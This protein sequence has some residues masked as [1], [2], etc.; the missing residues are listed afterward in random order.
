MQV[1]PVRG[2]AGAPEAAYWIVGRKNLDIQQGESLNGFEVAAELEPGARH[3]MSI[4][5]RKENFGVYENL[6]WRL[7]LELLAAD[8]RKI[9]AGRGY[10]IPDQYSLRDP[11]SL[12]KTTSTCRRDPRWRR[13]AASS[14]PP[15]TPIRRTVSRQTPCWSSARSRSNRSA[16][17]SGAKTRR[18]SRWSRR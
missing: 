18:S 6:A 14:S 13:F 16:R 10:N 8:G 7:D 11:R 17:S 9:A 12:T 2:G 4:L 1:P 5:C 15:N 3:R